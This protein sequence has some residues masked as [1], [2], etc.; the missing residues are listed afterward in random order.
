MSTLADELATDPSALGYKA[1]LDAG[2]HQEVAAIL[3]EPR[4]D[5]VGAARIS[6]TTLLRWG[7]QNGRIDAL[8][9]AVDS[10]TDAGV[11]SIADAALRMIQRADTG[12][13]LGTDDAM[14]QA[15]VD[16]GVFTAADKTSLEALSTAKISRAAQLGL[17]RVTHQ[18]VRNAAA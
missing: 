17:G 3:N 2:N 1:P 15:L 12:L 6:S 14:V 10:H 7:A 5:T 9:Q 18:E 4:Y 16:A 13:E 11:R 8:K